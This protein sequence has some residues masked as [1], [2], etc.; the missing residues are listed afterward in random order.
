MKYTHEECLGF[1][2]AI[3]TQVLPGVLQA[4]GVMPQ[5]AQKQEASAQQQIQQALAE[6][7]RRQDEQRRR[8]EEERRRRSQ[9]LTYV[10]AGVVGVGALGLIAYLALGKR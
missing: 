10:G 1:A 8:D 6:E 4:T 7:R 3:L 5:Q 9:T 2:P